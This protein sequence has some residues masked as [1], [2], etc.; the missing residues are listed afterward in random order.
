[1]RKKTTFVNEQNNLKKVVAT[2]SLEYIKGIL[3]NPSDCFNFEQAVWLN[4]HF[5]EIEKVYQAYGYTGLIKFYDTHSKKG[6]LEVIEQNQISSKAVVEF[7]QR[8]VLNEKIVGAYINHP[9][10]YKLNPTFPNAKIVLFNKICDGRDQDMQVL[11]DFLV[12][13]HIAQII[14]VSNHDDMFIAQKELDQLKRK[15]N[16]A[17]L[18]K[19][20]YT[21]I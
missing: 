17:V 7:R 15:N 13:K 5:L 6:L 9:A 4:H 19:K 14:D 10:K 12:L 3:H 11:F 8:L 20:I 16:A 21:K 2:R 1:M 18:L